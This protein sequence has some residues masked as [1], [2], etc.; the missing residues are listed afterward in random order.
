[1]VLNIQ[2]WSNEE[3]RGLDFGQKVAIYNLSTKI[4]KNVQVE[5]LR[6]SSASEKV[7]LLCM[8]LGNVISSILSWLVVSIN[9]YG[10]LLYR[11][12]SSFGQVLAKI[13]SLVALKILAT[14]KELRLF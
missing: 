3:G 4:Y 11:I 7:F 5:P 8:S 14:T 2:F 9:E 6:Y 12:T 10:C 13:S 1:M